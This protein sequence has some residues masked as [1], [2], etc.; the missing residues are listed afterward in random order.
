[1]P[2]SPWEN[3]FSES[4]NARFRDE[5]RD[6]N[7]GGATKHKEATAASGYK[8]PSDV[9]VPSFAACIAQ[10]KANV[11]ESVAQASRQSGKS[12]SFVSILKSFAYPG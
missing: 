4:S 10:I 5:L 9:I 2:N 11:S 8:P 6:D 12:L 7:V 3:E 1:M